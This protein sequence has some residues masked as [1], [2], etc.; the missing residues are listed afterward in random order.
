MA[1]RRMFGGLRRR[2]A[3]PYKRWEA[4]QVAW[5][6]NRGSHDGCAGGKYAVVTQQNAP[7]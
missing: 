6:N 3:E 4:E 7:P 5:E 2:A 1:R